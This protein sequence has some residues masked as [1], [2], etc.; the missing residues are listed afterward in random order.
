MA[1][2]YRSED[3]EDLQF[4]DHDYE[5][6]LQKGMKKTWNRVKWTKEEDDKL[7]RLVQKHGSENWALVSRHFPSRSDIQCQHRWQKVLN[8]ELIKGPWTKE[9]DQRV[10]ELV[11][12]YGPKRWSL[13]A[14]HL[15]GRIGKQCRERWHN[16]LNPEVKKSSW[17]EEEDRI[18]YGAHKR[19]GNRWAEIA[20]LLPGRTDNSIKN[21]WNSTMKR[22]V[23]Q[24]G[25]LQDTPA[26][27]SP[28]VHQHKD[29][30]Q[31]QN[32]FYMPVQTQ[33]P[34]YHYMSVDD[35]GLEN[36]Q[37]SF[38]FIQRP[39]VDVDDPDKEK[40]IKELELLLMSAENEVR[41]KRFSSTGSFS[42][43]SGSYLIE[44]STCN[45]LN[46]FEE[47]VSGFYS[48]D[49][50]RS[51]PLQQ[52]SPNKILTMERSATLSSLDVIPEFA[53]TLD[54]IES[55][56]VSWSSVAS[57]D[58]S[59]IASPTKLT[60]IK[61]IQTEHQNSV[62]TSLN[63][64]L[65]PTEGI[66]SADTIGK[67]VPCASPAMSKF[68]TPPAILRKKKMH[69]GQSSTPNMNEGF[70]GSNNV[71]R[72]CTPVKTLPFSP[73]QFFNIHSGNAQ[74]Q[75][76]LET[77]SFTSTPKCA[78]NGPNSLRKQLTPTEEEKENIGTPTTKRSLLGS[79]PRT[80]TPFKNALA[81]QE[82]KYGPLKVVVQALDFHEEDIRE[83][84]KQETGK[85]VFIKEE[86][87]HVLKT[88]SQE[89]NSAFKKV[90]KSLKL[91]ALDKEE[92]G[93]RPI[94]EDDLDLH[95][96][97]MLS[98]PLLMIPLVER[99][100]WK[101]N[102]DVEGEQVH[103]LQKK[104]SNPDLQ[105]VK[106]EK[107]FQSIGEWEAVVYGKTE[108][109]LIMTEQARQYLGAFKPTTSTTSRHL[110]L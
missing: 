53:E 13:I 73:S 8:P 17:T 100:D 64:G 72:K 44:D 27:Q 89:N 3:E 29:H 10:I 21:H 12:K 68:S 43:W 103:F 15:K 88:C 9:E 48:M 1:G 34:G 37:N 90:R 57:F 79:M 54:L 19:I 25:Y 107:P 95:N 62:N 23:E 104:K 31:T 16:H 59:I 78:K 58:V 98:T 45:T 55:D 106:L 2:R 51:T 47:E 30:M 102:L 67:L 80:P 42:N 41:R 92:L 40:R 24:E 77:P 18:I 82:R 5:N 33:I 56:P 109:Q 20:K 86:V 35:Q 38:A 108:D 110:V 14:K 99:S 97:N 85:D 26:R 6:S 74:E 76:S 71:V 4:A 39:F 83:V 11:Q 28:S 50:T 105:N 7:K 87:P 66:S 32:H 93:A 46:S 22:K 94:P 69:V 70:G 84:L 75:F 91:D 52:S 63:C 60:P 36:V 49:E 81:A 96:E 61:L 101:G 65:G